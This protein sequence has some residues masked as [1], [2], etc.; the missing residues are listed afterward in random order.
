MTNI[1]IIHIMPN[2]STHYDRLDCWCEP[3]LDYKDYL[4]GNEVWIHKEVH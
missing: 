1:E 4:N 2:T 3:T